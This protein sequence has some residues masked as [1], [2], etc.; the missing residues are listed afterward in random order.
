MGEGG[1]AGTKIHGLR[2]ALKTRRAGNRP[3]K[4]CSR[5]AVPKS[6]SLIGLCLTDGDNNAYLVVAFLLPVEVLG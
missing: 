5:P 1:H 4:I 2:P 3:R 6:Q